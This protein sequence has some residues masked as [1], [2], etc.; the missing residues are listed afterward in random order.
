MFWVVFFFCDTDNS[1]PAVV[2]LLTKHG[3]DYQTDD[4]VFEV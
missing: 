2:L 1:V 3:A 4:S